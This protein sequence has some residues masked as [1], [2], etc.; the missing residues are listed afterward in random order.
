MS[1][2][3]P[4]LDDRRFQD[5][6]DEA[7]RLIPNFLP[8]WTNHNVSDPGVAL[9]E[10]FAWMTELTLYRLNRVP[11]RLYTSFLDLVGISPYPAEAAL[12]PV[13]F[14][15]STVPDETVLIPKGTE[16]ATLGDDP[17][18]FSTL[19]DLQVVQPVRAF[20][21]TTSSNGAGQ[22]DEGRLKDVIEDLVLDNDSVTV[23]SSDPVEP[24]D[25]LYLGFRESLGGCMLRLDI[26]ADIEGIGVNPTRPPIIWEVWTVEG[27]T[28]CLVQSD[29]TGG[30]NRDGQINIAVPTGH[31]SHTLLT[32]NAF[33]LRLRLLAPGRDGSGYRTSP[34]IKS[35]EIHAVGGTAI[36]E[37]SEIYGEEYLGG[38]DGTPAQSF[39]IEASPILPRRSYECVEVRQGEISETWIEVSDFAR[40]TLSDKHFMWDSTSGQVQ[41]GPRIRQNNGDWLQHGAVPQAGASIWVTGYRRG[42]GTRGNVGAGSLSVLRSAVPY[43]DQVINNVGATGGIDP[44]TLEN[45]KLRAPLTL[46]SAGRAVTVSDHERLAKAATSRVSRALCVPPTEAGL[47]TR[48]LIVPDPGLPP[49]AI[50]IDSLALDDDLFNTLVAY[51]E[52]RRL[53]GTSLE[54]GTPKYVGV[55][56]TAMVRVSPGRASAAIQQKCIDAISTF[57]SPIDGGQ[58]GTG[59]PFGV[60]LTSGSISNLLGE[61]EGVEQVEE[62]VLFESDLRNGN[63]LGNGSETIRFE[64][65]CLPISFRPRVVLR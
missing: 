53:I 44:E 8:E 22:P 30:L 56:V 32:E 10:L 6:V 54:L 29:L 20:V 23:F 26:E 64:Q 11:D 1:F 62:V 17:V 33:W 61:I 52:P 35:L 31:L 51:L 3:I 19:E 58:D 59:W 34:K 7:K 41:F 18:V 13:S 12:V 46:V 15:F 50:E 55:S 9:I 60:D 49:G 45:A 4:N 21:W 36:M 39:A 47:S 27:W 38:S 5:L 24:G 2:P 57:L 43:V 63:R 28:P 48:L 16:V 25:S 40:S 42:G 65:F 37:H 14:I